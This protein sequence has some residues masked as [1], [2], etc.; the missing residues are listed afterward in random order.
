MIFDPDLTYDRWLRDAA[1][2]SVE[3]LDDD[4]LGEEGRELMDDFRQAARV[5]RTATGGISEETYHKRNEFFRKWS[6][7]F[8]EFFERQ[9]RRGV[10]G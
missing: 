7:R 6:G 5:K 8:E 2:E 9:L 1:L 3:G 4:F 10:L